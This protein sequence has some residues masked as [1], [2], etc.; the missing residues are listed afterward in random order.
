MD[1]LT[2][3]V[4]REKWRQRIGYGSSDFACNLIWQVISLYL[5]YFYTNVMH[6]DAKAISIMFLVTKIFDGV[7]D[8]V[9][10]FLIDK[11]DT[12]W[13]KSRPWI[14]GGAIPFAVTSVLAFSVPDISQTGMLIYAYVTYMLLSL[15]YTIVNIP[16]ASILTA[17]SEDANERTTLASYRTFFASLGSTVVSASALTLVEYFGGENEALGFRMVMMLFGIIG[18]IV[19]F[20]CFFNTKERVRVETE[21]VSIVKNLKSLIHN[22]PWVLFA[23]NI[24]WY[25]GGYAIEAGAL[26][27]YFTYIVGNAKL[28][29]LV[30][31]IWTLVPIVSNL[32][33]PFI[34]KFTKKRNVMIMG[35]SIQIAGLLILAAGGKTVPILVVGALISAFGHGMKKSIH[36]AMQPDPVDYGEWK[37]GVNTSGTLSAVNGFIGK[38]GMAIASSLGAALLAMGG[39]DSEAAV[40]SAEAL[41][42]I[43]AMYIWIP[44]GTCVLSIITMLFYDLDKKHAK[45]I[46]ELNERRARE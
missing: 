10:G 3:H 19:F 17:L 5:L 42:C 44:I 13:G 29:S 46:E 18:C 43:S 21:K 37:D 34:V 27:Y 4:K 23:L 8:L 45:I 31:T 39:F 1:E 30:A 36:F 9:V 15:S 6:L 38:V 35:C 12:R 26:I 7:T 22:K 20:F 40:Q 11:T 24:I 25:F 14:A 32:L 28:A 33:V 41:R 16:M 2:K